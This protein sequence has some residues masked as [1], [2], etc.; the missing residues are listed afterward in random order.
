MLTNEEVDS[1]APKILA[2]AIDKVSSWGQ[3]HFHEIRATDNGEL[4]PVYGAESSEG[5]GAFLCEFMPLASI[6]QLFAVASSL[7]IRL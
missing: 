7:S 1:L 3:D 5:L 4:V 6:K 2:F